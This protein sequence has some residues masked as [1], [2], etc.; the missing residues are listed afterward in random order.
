MPVVCKGA[1]ILNYTGQSA[2]VSAYSP[3]YEPHQL[4]VVDAAVQYDCPYQMKLYIYIDYTKCIM[5]TLNEQPS[6]ASLYIV[7][8]RD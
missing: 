7:G 1:Y 6:N 8:G 5:H 4:P 3:E 2:E